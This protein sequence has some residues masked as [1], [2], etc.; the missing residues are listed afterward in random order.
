MVIFNLS[1]VLDFFCIHENFT[2]GSNYGQELLH[3]VWL[4]VQMIFGKGGSRKGG[5]VY[6]TV[7]K[8]LHGL[9]VGGIIYWDVTPLGKVLRSRSGALSFS[10]LVTYSL[11]SAVLSFK[12]FKSQL[13]LCNQGTKCF[14]MANSKR[15]ELNERVWVI[16]F[17]WLQYAEYRKFSHA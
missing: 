13:L 14:T 4:N 3:D 5:F 15:L 10:K 16:V 12:K 6:G 2:T 7:S 9:I 11:R 17:L 1:P 8:A